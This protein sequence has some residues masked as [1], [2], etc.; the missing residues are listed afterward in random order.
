M[1]TMYVPYLLNKTA[2]CSSEILCVINQRYAGR[3]RPP[4]PH[5]QANNVNVQRD[6]IPSRNL[7]Y[8]DVDLPP[9][10]A[11]PRGR[12]RGNN[13]SAPGSSLSVIYNGV[14]WRSSPSILI[15]PISF[16]QLI[17]AYLF[18]QSHTPLIDENAH[19]NPRNACVPSR[20]LYVPQRFVHVDCARCAL[21]AHDR[22]RGSGCE[23]RCVRPTDILP[24]CAHGMDSG[25]QAQRYLVCVHTLRKHNQHTYSQTK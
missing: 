17:H 6:E 4:Y 18:Q 2:L 5:P 9:Q 11:I 12:D 19:D 15:L 22:L 13:G 8:I 24:K 14:Y 23:P 25:K 20:P 1:T 21:S 16:R 3:S 10:E 7:G